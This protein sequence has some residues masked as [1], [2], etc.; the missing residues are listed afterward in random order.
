[1]AL[2]FCCMP[3][4][5]DTLIV[6]AGPIGIELAV[7][8]KRAGAPYL[9][10]DA[11]AVG[12]TMSWWA[13]GTK[14]FSSPERIGIAGVPLAVPGQEKATREQYL[15]YLLAVVRQFGLA[16]E[17]HTRVESLRPLDEPDG[18]GARF[19]LTLRGLAGERAVRARSVV[20]AIG[21]MHRPRLLGVP[22]EDLPH[23]SHFLDDPR[24]Y[25]GKRVLIVG[26]K[27]SAVEAAIR[28]Y[29]AGVDVA[30]SYRRDAFSKRVKYW[31]RPELE[32]LI[33]RGSIGFHPNTVPTRIEPGRVT[34]APTDEEGVPLEAAAG[35]G[36]ARA[37]DA[38]RVDADLVLLLTGYEQDTTLFEQAGVE[39]VG[40]NRAPRHDEGT[41][42]TNA[43]GLYV[44]GTAAAG[45]QVGGVTVFIETA[46]VHCD[47]IAAH[48]L[49]RRG[50]RHETP[51]YALPES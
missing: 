28:L 42:E 27:N 3:E 17:T 26:G 25:Y 5:H 11:G 2:E 47:R 10:V 33:K 16:I 37:A 1:M 18:D 49:G 14:F 15:D 12:E 30:I 7:A 9:H 24:V 43:P 32:Y 45:T 13:P 50:E 21:D 4:F 34:L 40:D 29:R 36:S 38:A 8:L 31:L 46:H 6:G 41:M 48:L 51:D 23:V 20:L 22:G 39:L 35:N 44:A 19:E